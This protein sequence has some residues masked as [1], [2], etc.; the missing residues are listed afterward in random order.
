L[1]DRVRDDSEKS[2]D[3]IVEHYVMALCARQTVTELRRDFADFFKEH[4][5]DAQ[6][7]EEQLVIAEALRARL[8]EGDDPSMAEFLKWFEKWFLRRAAPVGQEAN[9]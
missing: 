1:L 5:A 2:R 7:L 8:T 3:E 6:R 4:A 9:A